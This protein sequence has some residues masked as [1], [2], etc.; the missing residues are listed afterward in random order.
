MSSGQ[1]RNS[2]HSRATVFE[3]EDMQN[4][5]KTD[6]IYRFDRP[7]SVLE[8]DLTEVTFPA[9]EILLCLAAPRADRHQFH[10]ALVGN[11]TL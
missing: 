5:E 3:F 11:S 1:G 10:P 2:E 8:Q 6:L 4:E 7:K 9:W